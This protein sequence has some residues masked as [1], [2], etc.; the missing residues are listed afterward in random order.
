MTGGKGAVVSPEIETPS[1]PKTARISRCGK[2]AVVSP[3]IE[4]WTVLSL[5]AYARLVARE[6]WSRLRLKPVAPSARTRW[7]G[8]WQGTTVALLKLN[9]THPKRE[10]TL[11]A[12][13]SDMWHSV[14]VKYETE[15]CMKEK[16]T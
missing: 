14:L 4:T 12:L 2:G 10:K 7:M 1:T 15:C 11:Q 16:R 8:Q 13:F 6:R 3:E 5:P 9:N